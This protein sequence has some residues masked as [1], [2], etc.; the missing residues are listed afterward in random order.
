MNKLSLFLLSILVINFSGCVTI[1]KEY[2]DPSWTR[3]SVQGAWKKNPDRVYRNSSKLKYGA[4]E[5]CE[6]E[7]P[8]GGTVDRYYFKNGKVIEVESIVYENL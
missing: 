2:F 3:E 8:G 5:I 4:D 7:Y 6:W 1:S